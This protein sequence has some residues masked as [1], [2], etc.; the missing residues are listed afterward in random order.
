MDEY[1]GYIENLLVIEKGKER[2]SHLEHAFG[3]FV[4]ICILAE[5]YV[6]FG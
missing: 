2:R 4:C 5:M 6:N 1:L 3:E